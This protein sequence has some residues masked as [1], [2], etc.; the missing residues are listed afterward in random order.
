MDEYI[1]VVGWDSS[2]ESEAA[3]RAAAEI[4]VR[5]NATI[6]VV[7]A[8][9]FLSQPAP[10]DPTFHGDDAEAH[11][12]RAAERLLPASLTFTTVAVLGL[13]DDVLVEQSATADIIAI[14]RSG[15]GRAL[16]P[17]VGSTA[18]AI[19]RH[20]HCPVLVVPNNL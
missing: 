7:L 13:A 11:V 8:W 6:R 12:A 10:F 1:I 3:V 2:D 14:G 17:L 18:T 19:V 5:A 4:A 15:L 20:A 9:D 16:A